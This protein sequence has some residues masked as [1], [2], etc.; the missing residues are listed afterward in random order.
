MLEKNIVEVKKYIKGMWTQ[1]LL[2]FVLLH[3]VTDE[4]FH[5]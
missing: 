3:Q 5:P 2:L 1:L 4:G